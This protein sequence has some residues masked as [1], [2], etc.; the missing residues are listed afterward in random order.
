MKN[1]FK[2]VVGQ[3]CDASYEHLLQ[4]PT[5]NSRQRHITYAKVPNRAFI[6]PCMTLPPARFSP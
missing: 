5:T 4:E 1:D 6:S 2:P 3:L